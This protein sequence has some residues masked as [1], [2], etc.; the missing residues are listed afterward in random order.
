MLP[1]TG[2]Q[3]WRSSL[4]NCSISAP[5]STLPTAAQ[6]AQLGVSLPSSPPN[7]FDGTLT[8]WASD[9]IGG[10]GPLTAKAIEVSMAGTAVTDMSAIAAT[11]LVP[12]T[13]IACVYDPASKNG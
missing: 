2:P 11:T 3:S 10:G 1:V 8:V 13:G 4:A 12:V 5:N 7:P 9:V 6:L